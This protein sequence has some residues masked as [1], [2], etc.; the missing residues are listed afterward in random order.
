MKYFKKVIGER[1]YL[2]PISLEDTERY[3]E[4]LN[5]FDVAVNLVVAPQIISVPKEREF[6]ERASKSGYVFAI[7]D[8]ATDELLGNCGLDSVDLINRSAE[9]GIFIGNKAF[10]NKGY[11]T[12]AMC[13]LLDFSFN[14]LNLN[15]I[16]L[17]VYDF[18]ARAITSYRKCGFKE[19]GRRR[20]ARILAGTAHDVILMDMVAAD[21]KNGHIRI[22]AGPKGA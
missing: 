11:G 8:L 5:D 14:L 21:F 2:S 7:V 13:L 16:M 19:I 22:P 3:A 20:K 1:C 4:M 17:Q 6:V 10:W 9:C 18:N 15:N 12:E